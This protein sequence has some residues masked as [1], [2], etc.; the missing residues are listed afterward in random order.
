M[1]SNFCFI[2]DYCRH[3]FLINRCCFVVLS[4]NSDLFR[5][6]RNDNIFFLMQNFTDRNTSSETLKSICISEKVTLKVL[7]ATPVV[8]C[9]TAHASDV[10][11]RFSSS[12]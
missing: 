8:G 12:D 6:F 5:T 10:I 1:M 2:T 9:G 4:D 11:L 3:Y 7:L